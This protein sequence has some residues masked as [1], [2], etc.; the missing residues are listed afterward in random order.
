MQSVSVRNSSA[1]T[2]HCP[3]LF[4]S[5]Q[6]LAKKWVHEKQVCSVNVTDVTNC[7]HFSLK[8][9]AGYLKTKIKLDVFPSFFITL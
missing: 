1:S 8:S 3:N 2:V 5:F 6:Y 7:L 4:V 9:V